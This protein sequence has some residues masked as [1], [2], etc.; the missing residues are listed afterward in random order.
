MKVAS[1]LYVFMN[2]RLVG[3]LNKLTNGAMTF[4]YAEV[5]LSTTGA[6]PLSLSLPLRRQRYEGDQVYNFF[7]NLLPDSE[8]IRTRI[9]ARFKIASGQP[10]DLLAAIGSDCIGSIQLGWDAVQF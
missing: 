7:D 2:G 5:W 8:E 1:I 10:F 3:D 6:R 9:Q 4:Q